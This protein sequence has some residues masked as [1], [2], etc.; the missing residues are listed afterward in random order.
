MSDIEDSGTTV[1]DVEKPEKPTK[2]K[3]PRTEAQKKA[4]AK[5]LEALAE[6]RAK[7]WAEKEEAVAKT[8]KGKTAVPT[9]ATRPTPVPPPSTPAEPPV[10]PTSYEDDIKALKAELQALKKVPKGKAKAPPRNR[11]KESRNMADYDYEESDE[12]VEEVVVR[13]PKKVVKRVVRKVYEEEEDEQK[14]PYMNNDV[15]QSIFFRNM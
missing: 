7:K 1:V 4:T 5:A 10:A 14:H 15:L 11:V 12:E 2:Q 6:H 9:P 3:K 8:P 13:K